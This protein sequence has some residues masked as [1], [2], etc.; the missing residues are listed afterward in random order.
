[1]NI[2]LLLHTIFTKADVTTPWPLTPGSYESETADLVRSFMRTTEKPLRAGS[3]DRFFWPFKPFVNRV[4]F[5]FEELNVVHRIWSLP[6][7]K[8]LLNSFALKTGPLFCFWR[9]DPETLR[10]S[11]KKIPEKCCFC[12]FFSFFFFLSGKRTKSRSGLSSVLTKVSLPL[13]YDC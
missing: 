6:N 4:F 12:L 11:F 3:W 10:D 13:Y 9:K 8:V 1:M 7:C 5:K 2:L